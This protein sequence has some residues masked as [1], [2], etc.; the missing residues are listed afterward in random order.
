MHKYVAND[1]IQTCTKWANIRT[2][3]NRCNNYVVSLGVMYIQCIYVIRQVAFCFLVAFF[4][5]LLYIV[6]ISCSGAI[7]S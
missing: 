3:L 7:I 1:G 5:I 4:K 6:F 2:N